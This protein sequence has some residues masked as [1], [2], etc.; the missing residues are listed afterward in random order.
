MPLPVTEGI[1]TLLFM[2]PLSLGQ[3]QKQYFS[4]G[5][6]FCL[7]WGLPLFKVLKVAHHEFADRDG[8]PAPQPD[9]SWV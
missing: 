8:Q 7:T 5:L 3:T 6:Q 1:A 9:F 2:S 4:F